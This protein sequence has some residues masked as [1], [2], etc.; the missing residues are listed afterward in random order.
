MIK[1]L[2]KD[3]S[4]DGKLSLEEHLEDTTPDFHIANIIGTYFRNRISERPLGILAEKLQRLKNKQTK[5]YKVWDSKYPQQLEE[6]V[7]PISFNF[8]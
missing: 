8:H 3:T 6:I 4:K 1:H 2:K 7:R 5:M